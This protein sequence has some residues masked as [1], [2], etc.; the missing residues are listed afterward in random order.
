MPGIIEP[1]FIQTDHL[2]PVWSPVQWDLTPEERVIELENQATSS[3]LAT[4]D[5]PEAIIR[6]L[7]REVEIERAYEPPQ[8]YDPDQQGEWEEDL[9]TFAFKHPLKLVQ[10]QRKTEYLL[11]EY[12][13]DALGYWM[14]EIKPEEIKLYR[15]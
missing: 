7:L 10:V 14:M 13:F 8:G 9:V 15:V 4:A 3:L 2:P 6:L 12:D 1:E 5:I 11:L